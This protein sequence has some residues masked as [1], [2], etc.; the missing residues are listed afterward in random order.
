MSDQEISQHQ[1]THPPST[2][3][4]AN[5][6]GPSA[7]V[8]PI[9]RPSDNRSTGPRTAPGKQRSK[10]NALK[11]GFLSKEV[12]LKG[13]S[14][15]QYET[16][17]DG[18][19]NDYDPVGTTENLL[20]EILAVQWWRR[21]RLLQ[22]E[23]AEISKRNFLE[24]DACFTAETQALDYAMQGRVRDG[25][26]GS[27]NLATIREA[28]NCLKSMHLL[29]SSDPKDKRFAAYLRRLLRINKDHQY[30]D[31]FIALIHEVSGF[32]GPNT[33]AVC[34][35]IKEKMDH[36]TD[37]YSNILDN[38]L[39]K[40]P[41]NVAAGG[42]PSEQ[43]SDRLLRYESQLSREIDRAM[44]QLDRVQRMRKGQPIPRIDIG[45]AS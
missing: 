2:N 4:K 34:Q 27:N 23:N 26:L 19:R 35:E 7:K 36:L 18:L 40:I 1:E 13:E 6:S 31:R 3:A 28:L 25:V 14:R 30:D 9:E 37:L 45:L 38:K 8:G 43:V 10:F 16:L 12:L 5:G 17:L 32:P 33:E 22:V 39:Q 21:R 41:T 44:N 20:V 15:A 24:M 29:L 11:H 42:I